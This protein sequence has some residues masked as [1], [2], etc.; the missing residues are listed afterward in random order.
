MNVDPIT[1]THQSAVNGANALTGSLHTGTGINTSTDVK[2]FSL[3]VVTGTTTTCTSYF[4]N[5]AN[6]NG[7]E[8]SPVQLWHQRL[9]HL[10][11]NTLQLVNQQYQLGMTKVQLTAYDKLFCEGCV[12]AKGKRT[13]IGT[14]GADN[15]YKPVAPLGLTQWDLVGP[16]NAIDPKTKRKHYLTTIGGNLYGLIG[17]DVYTGA[18]FV[19]TIGTKSEAASV[20][21]ST[22]KQLSIQTG[23]PIRRVHTDM[24]TEFNNST[25]D[26]FCNATG[27]I[28]TSTTGYTPALNGA[29]ERMVRSLMEMVRGWM[30]NSGAP[31]T[32][33]GEALVLAAHVYNCIPHAG[34]NQTPYQR[35]YG[36]K[37][38]IA[39]TI[40]TFGCNAL[41]RLHDHQ[42][43]KV[44]PKFAS[45]GV[46]LGY[47][48]KHHSYRILD[49]V[50]NTIILTRDARFNENSFT[51]VRSIGTTLTEAQQQHQ[52]SLLEPTTGGV[53]SSDDGAITIGTS[54][55]GTDDEDIILTGSNSIDSNTNTTAGGVSIDNTIDME[56]KYDM[57]EPEHGDEDE[58]DPDYQ[59]D[60]TSDSIP[61]PLEPSA[62]RRSTRIATSANRKADD[63]YNLDIQHQCEMLDE[64]I[65]DTVHIPDD[66]QHY[67]IEDNT[68]TGPTGTNGHNGTDNSI[69]QE[70][71]TTKAESTYKGPV[72]RSRAHSETA[73]EPDAGT[74][75]GT[76]G[77]SPPIAIVEEHMEQESDG[78]GMIFG[79]HKYYLLLTDSD[80][81]PKGYNQ[82]Q[83]SRYG[84]QWSNAMDAEID[85]LIQQGTWTRVEC[86]P[87]AKPISCRWVYVI[88][89]TS[90]GAIDKFKARLVV[91]GF[92]QQ[93]GIDFTDTF[94]PVV[95]F[96]SLKLVLALTAEHDLE[97]KQIDFSNA[98][99]NATLAEK[100][101]MME[102]PGY[103]TYTIGTNGKR[104]VLLLNKALY[105]LKQSPRAWNL[106]LHKFLVSLGY[107]NCICDPC[108]YTKRTSTGTILLC[109]YVDDTIIAYP[110][111]VEPVWL[112]DLTKLKEKYKL[113][114]GD[115]CKWVLRMSVVRD[116]TKRTI[117]LKQD[118]Y[119]R[120]ML[121]R[122]H[123]ANAN[124]VKSS[125]NDD[126]IT[127]IIRTVT[128]DG[129]TNNTNS[130]KSTNATST[131]EP[132]SNADHDIYMSI[133]GSLM[134]ASNTLRP[135]ITYVTGV[136]A[137]FMTAPV[138][139]HM[140]AAKHVLRYLKGTM[141]YGLVFMPASTNG[142][143]GTGTI[144]NSSSTTGTIDHTPTNALDGKAP[145]VHNL[146]A[147]TDASW[148]NDLQDRKSTTGSVIMYNGNTISWISK[149]QSTVATSTV[150]S[151]YMALADTTKE[152]LW[153]RTWLNEVF[154]TLPSALVLCD[155]TGAIALSAKDNDHQRTKHIDIKYHFIRD[156]IKNGTIVVKHIP[157]G[158]Q[159]ADLLTKA[160]KA[161][162]FTPLRDQV[163]LGNSVRGGV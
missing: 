101:Y 138:K 10:N 60:S 146:V 25:I 110:K 24:G 33:W 159:L 132:L 81:I 154:G 32:L 15:Q 102:P 112:A 28:H 63:W 75:T 136:L 125:C 114:G 22:L 44:D 67:H 72:T 39:R 2:C 137:R 46:Y 135:D 71:A 118:Q 7:T 89:R 42:R 151:E 95:K 73:S 65:I 69:E 144:T 85:Q 155:N 37:H 160:L 4:L 111:Q 53:F 121:D 113:T 107:T 129:I 124:P 34:A 38:N 98:F 128:S 83:K 74:N 117:T 157:T 59:H 148:G 29:A 55:T 103:E 149:K 16:L 48:A 79:N 115:D 21:I 119:I 13:N 142:A 54:P 45:G 1:G 96:K 17:V 61:S 70:P 161:P 50:H 49:T 162:V 40:R 104:M 6:R 130:T 158:I 141:D 58:N 41:W 82:A 153:Y 14:T 99:L 84:P 106:E 47:D 36:I 27:A 100:V 93:Y 134:Y 52:W 163:M 133:V 126:D 80:D 3:P 127:S 78:T 147:Y 92:M 156:H 43:S 18:A 51:N 64:G 109:L 94:A 9:G 31:H 131:D 143:T 90:T 120:E 145:L 150:E 105:G 20:L 88:K 122:Y 116:R 77:K 57:F 91:R 30:Y 35:L 76:T 86:P 97:L 8:M 87:G 11:S 56:S 123:M 26:A 23:Y 19:R 139:K 66:A 62:P 68:S 12:M 140:T 5:S 108:M 152:V